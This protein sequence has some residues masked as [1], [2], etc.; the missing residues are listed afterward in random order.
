[1]RLH[2]GVNMLP[3]LGD[4]LTDWVSK[5]GIVQASGILL[6]PAMK[7]R[8]VT[9]YNFITHAPVT[10]KIKQFSPHS[11]HYIFSGWTVWGS[12]ISK[13]QVFPVNAG[14]PKVV[15]NFGSRR[16]KEHHTGES[17]FE[18]LPADVV[19]DFLSEYTHVMSLGIMVIMLTIWQKTERPRKTALLVGL[20][21]SARES[22]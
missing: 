13:H 22:F 11:R 2:C 20:L 19:K 16:Q 6:W 17:P 5:L 9:V 10:A 18:K 1:M 4:H 21:S 3:K 12:S 7:L 8:M 15:T 14:W